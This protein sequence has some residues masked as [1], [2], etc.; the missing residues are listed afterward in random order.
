MADALPE[1]QA[2]KY[3]I[4]A[5][6]AKFK[7]AYL[8]E[9]KS[10]EQLE[11]RKAQIEKSLI[12]E[13]KE[14]GTKVEIPQKEIV[15]A[16]AEIKAIDDILADHK[17]AN[18]AGITIEAPT[19]QNQPIQ[20]GEDAT[21]QKA[22][23]NG[24]TVEQPM[25]VPEP[26]TP[27]ENALTKEEQDAV[28][29]ISKADFNTE[30]GKRV[31]IWTDIISDPNATI[32]NKKQALKELGEQLADKNS[33]T[34]TGLALGKSADAIYN[35]N[36]ANGVKVEPLK[37]EANE[38]PQVEVPNP[39][40][41]EGIT[42]EG[43]N[44]ESGAAK[45]GEGQVGQGEVISITHAATDA[46]ARELG[47]SEY[48]QSPET[49]AEWDAEVN[50]RLAENPNAI[51]EM[52]DKY[53]AGGKIDKY[54][55]R[56][57]LKYHA[58]LKARINESPTPENIKA[59]NEAKRLSDIEGGREVAKSLVARKGN[60]PVEDDLANFLVK[61]ANAAGVETLPQETINELKKKYDADQEV[62][63]QLNGRIE[64]LEKDAADKALKLISD[65]TD[66]ASRIMSKYNSDMGITES[67]IDTANR[68]YND[69]YNAAVQLNASETE[70]LGIRKLQSDVI[71]K[72]A[73]DEVKAAAARSKAA[74]D[75][76]N[77]I[78]DY[79]NESMGIDSPLQSQ[80]R[81]IV[82]KFDEAREAAKGLAN[83]T[84]VLTGIQ[85]AQSAMIIKIVDDWKKAVVAP[86]VEIGVALFEWAQTQLK[87]ST[88]TIAQATYAFKTSMINQSSMT[89]QAKIEATAGALADFFTTIIS[90]LEK[91]YESLKSLR[92]DINQS[93]EDINL[94]SKTTLEQANFFGERAWSGHNALFGMLDED[95]PEAATKVKADI[96][97]Y[98]ELEKQV[99]QEKY[100]TEIDA[101]KSKS[102][103]EIQTIQSI[104][105]KLL[106]LRYSNFNLALPGQ[107]FAMANQDY[108]TMFAAAQT[109]DANAISKYLSFTDTALQASMDANKSSQTYLDFYAKVMADIASL[110]KFGGKT[111]ESLTIDQNALIEAQ[112]KAMQEE[113][114]ALDKTTIDALGIL[115]GILDN[116]IK[117][118]GEN[119]VTTM[120]LLIDVVKMGYASGGLSAN[121]SSLS[122]RKSIYGGYSDGG[123]ASGPESGYMATL[124]GTELVVSPRNSVPVKMRGSADGYGDPEVKNLLRTLV[125][126]GNKKQNVILT[127]D[128]KT[129]TGVMEAV[130]DRL[131]QARIDKGIKNRNYR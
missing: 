81:A 33:E 32:E 57:M 90:G 37:I 110:D 97:K 123:I 126:Q 48:E 111:I 76:W 99:I 50:K 124:H 114:L 84:E 20:I 8:V 64:Q 26:I 100:Q 22:N 70:L 9:P 17:K 119:I 56:M 18:E 28:D 3:D 93:I 117:S 73:A 95:I 65:R 62:I 66:L 24:V 89:A 19:E 30:D 125:A 79:Y 42:D 53:R 116:R 82:K 130:A 7:N 103:V 13:T 35:L 60:I 77:G 21:I 54:D 39:T 34:E 45:E 71:N 36:D 67:P 86:F 122:D 83:E 59:Y 69:A 52:M 47:L 12:P 80:V 63:K 51:Q 2:E 104:R 10:P 85:D 109:G 61:E 105:D 118:V 107:K 112:T 102:Q 5:E 88:W 6:S 101:I 38:E 40:K 115:G 96:L 92:S 55:Q 87:Y 27:K 108:N 29:V 14:D 68:F 44:K 121:P 91:T 72:L 43:V 78:I 98:Y 113:L 120:N 58:A 94:S 31:K 106:S 15:A 46:V 127:I 49:I 4:E 1:K 41:E 75:Y 128:G 25:N 131:D 23:D 74:D 129:V 11:K 16:K